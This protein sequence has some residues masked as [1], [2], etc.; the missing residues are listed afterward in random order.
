MKKT[1]NGYKKAFFLACLFFTFAT[2]DTAYFLLTG[3][4]ADGSLYFVIPGLILA[5]LICGYFWLKGYHGND[6]D[7]EFVEK[8]F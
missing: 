4:T 2:L 1:F 3:S 8:F 6:S 5:S 7:K